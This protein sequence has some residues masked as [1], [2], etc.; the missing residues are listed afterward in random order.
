MNSS[1]QT[2]SSQGPQASA[3]ALPAEVGAVSATW[4][5]DPAHSSAGF[6]VR[7]LMVSHVRG[8]LGP[9]SGSVF[10][11]EQDLSRS[12]VDV[13]IA[14]SGIDTREPKRDEHL[15]SADFL[16]VANHPNVT[17]RSTRVRQAGAD[18]GLEVTGDLTIRG[19]TRA[20]TLAVEPLPPAVAD[21]WGNTKRGATASGRINRRDFGLVWNVALETGGVIVG[22]EV[23]IEIEVE[24]ARRKA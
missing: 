17:F 23:A 24:L 13:S 19:V 18:G 7:H 14:A 16:D 10:I 2:R 15:R 4:D 20:L 11:D 21:P 22:D 9:V 6:K 1:T 5:V 12:R 8:H 3:A